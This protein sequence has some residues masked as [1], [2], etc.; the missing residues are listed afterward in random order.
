[1]EEVPGKFSQRSQPLLIIQM[2]PVLLV[3]FGI[4]WHSAFVPTVSITEIILRGTIMYL[5]IFTILRF[6]LKREAG[7]VG[8]SDL[9]MMVLLADAA[10]N[11]MASEYKSV[12]EGLILVATIIFWNF[13]LDWLGYRFPAFRRL[14]QPPA[15]LLVKDGQMLRRK[16]RTEMITA[17]ELLSQVREQGVEK[18]EQVKSAYLESDGR[19]SVISRDPKSDGGSGKKEKAI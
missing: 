13:A 10:Q 19:I 16:M 12:P 4:D 7:T 8:M 11:G 17:D 3:L 6:V 1:M 15:I 2:T 5:G 9:L 14:V 18:I